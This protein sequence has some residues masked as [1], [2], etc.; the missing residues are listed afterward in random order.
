MRTQIDRLKQRATGVGIEIANLDQITLVRDTKVGEDG[1]VADTHQFLA[2]LHTQH[3]AALAIVDGTHEAG[4]ALNELELELITTA[5]RATRDVGRAA[6]LEYHAL[7]PLLTKPIVGRA[8]RLPAAEGED[9]ADLGIRRHLVLGI[10]ESRQSDLARDNI[11][12]SEIL[13]MKR[14]DVEQEVG[15][16]N[17]FDRKS[18]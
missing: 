1:D 10:E 11:F 4:A 8:F 18:K 5:I 12:L 17:G 15:V 2:V 7:C 9:P 3:Y 14:Q 13:A 6:A 16:A